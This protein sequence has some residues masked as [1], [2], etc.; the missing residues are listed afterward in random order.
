M[1]LNLPTNRCC[2]KS[3]PH[4]LVWKSVWPI[5][6]RNVV[7]KFNI[8]F[9]F[10]KLE[11][12]FQIFQISDKKKVCW[13]PVTFLPVFQ[14]QYFTDLFTILKMFH[15]LSLM[16]HK[17]WSCICYRQYG[18]SPFSSTSLKKSKYLRK[19]YRGNRICFYC[20]GYWYCLLA[21]VIPLW[22]NRALL[23]P[24]VNRCTGSLVACFTGGLGH[25]TRDSRFTGQPH[26]F[27]KS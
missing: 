27:C 17:S 16:L 24:R 6:H 21:P 20:I 14:V 23:F 12:G 13:G 25:W 18:I 3:E 22:K 15:K 1:F 9:I 8:F 7:S 4:E 2:F 5:L 11:H 26:M 19:G 10:L